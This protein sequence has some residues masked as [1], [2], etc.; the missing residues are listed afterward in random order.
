[1][2]MR[3][4]NIAPLQEKDNSRNEYEQKNGQTLGCNF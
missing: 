1:M 3:H 4:I 2:N